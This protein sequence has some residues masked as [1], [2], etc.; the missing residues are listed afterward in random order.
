MRGR[1]TLKAMGWAIAVAAA[2]DLCCRIFLPS[3]FLVRIEYL[4]RQRVTSVPAPDIQIVG[5]SVA[6]SG[7][8]STALTDGRLITR[9]DAMPGSSPIF[10]Y[11]LLRDEF[12]AGH[13]PK[14][15]VIA[16]SPHTF[17][18]VRYP[19]LI[20]S[21][22]H[23]REIPGLVLDSGEW[24]ASLYAVLT[25]I[26]YVLM[27]RD[28]F[29]AAVSRRELSFFKEPDESVQLISELTTLRRYQEGLL[30]GRFEKAQLEDEENDIY[31]QPFHVE[32]LN[33]KY[34]RKLLALAESKDVKVLWFTMPI[35]LGLKEAREQMGY[36]KS[37][38]QYLD[39]FQKQ[40]KLQIIRS[41]FVA[42][43]DRLFR[44]TLHLNAA[45]AAKLAC[46]LRQMRT[47]FTAD[48]ADLK[49]ASMHVRLSAGIV[50]REAATHDTIK[51]LEQVC[52]KA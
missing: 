5:D 14:V 7:F 51:I 48:I 2:I 30:K 24:T 9:N 36:G 17:R 20:G 25:R 42:Y 22:A 15:L 33:D 44:D 6:R 19:V 38:H 18:Q 23:W 41:E 3:G 45:G 21:F 37:L 47:A 40:G 11:L 16:H 32:S 29:K 43:E 12:D 49:A 39:Q 28:S 8:I 34:F 31:H 50:S 10:T 4:T 1:N 35:R 52:A 13:I 27:H 46:E 26:S